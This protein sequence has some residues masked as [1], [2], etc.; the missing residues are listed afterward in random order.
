MANQWLRLW[1][2]KPNDPKWRVIARHSKQSISVVLG[3][4]LHLVDDA[5]RREENGT[6]KIHPEYI[7]IALDEDDEAVE[8]VIQAMQGRV[9]DGNHLIDW[10]KIAQPS[11]SCLKQLGGTR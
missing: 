8:A 4:W 5:S 11:C 3:V 9:L 7:A 10:K 6:Y 2:D 1:H